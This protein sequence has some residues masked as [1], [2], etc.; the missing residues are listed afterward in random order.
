MAIVY[1]P[2]GEIPALA[3]TAKG[4]RVC[5]ACPLICCYE[6][7]AERVQAT[8]EMDAHMQLHLPEWCRRP[9][10]GDTNAAQS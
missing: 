3:M 6:T 1:Y 9:V 8:R 2:D 10:M 7:E 5:P 4:F